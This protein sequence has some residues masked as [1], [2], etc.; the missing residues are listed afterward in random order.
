MAYNMASFFRTLVLLDEVKCSSL[1]TSVPI[2][3]TFS[4]RVVAHARYTVFQMAGVA[5]FA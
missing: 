1:T 2:L 3:T 4:R 5:V